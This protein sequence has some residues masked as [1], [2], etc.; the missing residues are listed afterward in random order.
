MSLQ[1]RLVYELQRRVFVCLC[2]SKAETRPSPSKLC[3]YFFHGYLYSI[4]KRNKNPQMI[5]MFRPLCKYNLQL[6]HSTLSKRIK[7]ILTDL[8]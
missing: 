8:K 5:T 1:R 7:T 2:K 4:S 3:A 6:S